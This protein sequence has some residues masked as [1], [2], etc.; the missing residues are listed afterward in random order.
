M[1]TEQQATTG[2]ASA[3]SDVTVGSKP[4]LR[5]YQRGVPPS[6]TYE[7][8][9]LPELFDSAVKRFADR[10]AAAYF[11]ASLSYRDLDR[12]SAQFANRLQLFGLGKGD[13]VLVILPN[14]PQFLIAHFGILIVGTRGD[15]LVVGIPLR[16]LL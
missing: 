3:V 11:G 8:Q 10:T 5:S 4:W 12:L 6:L 13:R 1:A 15:E 7:A 14:V 9:T 2:E 16:Q